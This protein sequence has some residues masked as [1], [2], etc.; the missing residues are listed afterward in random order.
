MNRNIKI[1]FLLMSFITSVFF[2]SCDNN[3]INSNDKEIL[4]SIVQVVNNTY[5]NRQWLADAKIT[6]NEFWEILI[7]TYENDVEGFEKNKDNI[8]LITNTELKRV[9]K[10][11]YKGAEY[12]LEAYK[13]F[14]DGN[15]DNFELL[16]NQAN[17]LIY[18][19]VISLVEDFKI[20]FN[21]E[22]KE[23]YKLIKSKL[24]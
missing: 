2:I 8:A 1:I 18:P 3:K 7:E 4:D 16:L 5:K 22:I 20:K 23:E 13:E 24:E 10:N 9:L 11:Y 6:N 19:A 15:T 17:E 12:R 14:K 21:N